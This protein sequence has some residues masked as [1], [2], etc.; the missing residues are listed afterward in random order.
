M[1][2]DFYKQFVQERD[3]L[4]ELEKKLL[5]R[6]W[7]MLHDPQGGHVWTF[8]ERQKWYA[9]VLNSFWGPLLISFL[10]A[11]AMTFWVCISKQ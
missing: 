6:G 2:N 8:P 10:F 7:V 5:C 1:G 3:D 9:R 11:L 4:T